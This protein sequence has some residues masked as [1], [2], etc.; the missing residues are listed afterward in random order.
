MAIPVK[1]TFIIATISFL[2]LAS[3]IYGTW[4]IAIPDELIATRIDSHFS[5]NPFS[6]KTVNLRKGLFF[7]LKIDKLLVESDSNEIAILNNILC[8]LFNI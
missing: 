8:V 1:K 6:V 4:Y 3:V 5:K 7:D 2:F